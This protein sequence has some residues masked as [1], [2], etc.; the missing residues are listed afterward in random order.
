[1]R[2]SAPKG[3]A[4]WCLRERLLLLDCLVSFLHLLILSLRH[5]FHACACRHSCFT[6]V[7]M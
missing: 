3:L 1:M 7:L 5:P 6:T 4:V 2:Q